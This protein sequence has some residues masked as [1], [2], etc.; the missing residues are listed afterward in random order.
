[1]SPREVCCSGI[2]AVTICV[3]EV[4][5]SGKLAVTICVGDVCCSGK[6]AVTICV[7]S[8]RFGFSMVIRVSMHS[9]FR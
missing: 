4:C 6:L 7:E 2:L 5:C 9:G 1:M 8:A 3:G